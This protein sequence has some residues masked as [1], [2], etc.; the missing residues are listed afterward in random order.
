MRLVENSRSEIA[1]RCVQAGVEFSF[2]S[3]FREMRGQVRL[4]QIEALKAGGNE[5][6]PL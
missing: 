6:G 3:A 4:F 1:T 2:R 5:F